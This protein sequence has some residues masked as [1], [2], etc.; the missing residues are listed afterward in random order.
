MG[1][2]QVWEDNKLVYEYGD[3]NYHIINNIYDKDKITYEMIK[4]D[5]LKCWDK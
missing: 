2:I 3:R 4:E 1:S 5:I